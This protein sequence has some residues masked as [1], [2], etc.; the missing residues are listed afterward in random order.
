M[1]DKNKTKAKFDFDEIVEVVSC[2]RN[3]KK[4]DGLRGFI[5]GRACNED[6]AW[7]YSGLIFDFEECWFFY[8]GEL[9]STGEFIPEGLYDTGETIRVVVNKKGEGH[10][11]DE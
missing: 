11:K 8:E 2:I 3:G 1:N 10:I 5:A 9:K 4:L 6:G 7:S